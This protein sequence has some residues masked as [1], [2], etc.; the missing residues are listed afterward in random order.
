MKIKHPHDIRMK[1]LRYSL[2]TDAFKQ[3]VGIVDE[4]TFVAK[5]KIRGSIVIEADKFTSKIFKPSVV[6][7]D[8]LVPGMTQSVS[9]LW[10]KEKLKY[11]GFCTTCHQ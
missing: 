11:V 1:E 5:E 8:D 3:R 2:I 9:F 10:E 7:K 6:G 4:G